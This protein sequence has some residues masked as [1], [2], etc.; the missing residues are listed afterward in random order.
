MFMNRPIIL[1]SSKYLALFLIKVMFFFENIL[2]KYVESL[3][4]NDVPQ[5]FNSFIKFKV[6]FF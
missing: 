6:S 3:F 1:P 4:A 5:Y 2:D